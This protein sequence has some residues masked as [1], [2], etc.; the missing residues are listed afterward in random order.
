VLRLRQKLGS[1]YEG[2]IR[3]VPGVGY[4]IEKG[5]DAGAG[6]GRAGAV[7]EPAAGPVTILFTDIEGSTTLTQR[8]GDEAAQEVLRAHNAIVRDA[9]SAH[10]GSE[11]KH[12][13]DGI[14]ASFPLASKAL[15]CAVAIQK[16][17]AGRLGE[18]A[19]V[20]LR[21]RIGLNAGEPVSEEEDLFGAS[22]QLARRICD[23]AEP[24][25]ILVSAVVKGLAAGKRFSFSEM[26]AVTLRG[27]EEPLHLYEVS[28]QG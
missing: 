24:G 16:E 12:T 1:Q 9:L 10:S 3:S 4:K 18:Q 22:V 13:G 25:Q 5:E 26:G 21:V 19:V 23:A 17:I 2:L 6:S 28:W 15:D 27:F 14:M 8:L 20:H 11:V 7:A